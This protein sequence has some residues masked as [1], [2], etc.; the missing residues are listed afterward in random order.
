MK[1]VGVREFRQ[2]VVRHLIGGKEI[3][4]MRPNPTFC[5]E[6]IWGICSPY[7]LNFSKLRGKD[8]LI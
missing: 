1:F 8:A 7:Y 3:V 6:N 4:V 5:P 2:D